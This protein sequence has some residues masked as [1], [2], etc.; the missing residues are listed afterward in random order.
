MKNQK[1]FIDIVYLLILAL[2]AL[3]IYAVIGTSGNV[4]EIK[5]LAPNDMEQ[6]RGWSVIRYEGYQFGSFAKHGGKVWY[7]VKN[8]DNSSIQ[9]R[10]HVTMWNDELQYY[11]SKPEELSRFDIQGEASISVK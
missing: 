7:H 10:V 1:G 3:F 8:K 9:Y 5:K 2:V 4:E 11:Y 6:N